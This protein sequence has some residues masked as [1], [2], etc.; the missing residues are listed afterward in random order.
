MYQHLVVAYKKVLRVPN[1]TDHGVRLFSGF[2][3]QMR[4]VVEGSLQFSTYTRFRNNRLKQHAP[5]SGLRRE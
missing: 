5:N 2:G 1:Q 4:F 3:C